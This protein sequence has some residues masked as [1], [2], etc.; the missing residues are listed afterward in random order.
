MA[1]TPN[2]PTTPSET[3]NTDG[4]HQA[5]T[6]SEIDDIN[7]LAYMEAVAGLS[8]TSQENEDD[9]DDDDDEEVDEEVEDEEEDEETERKYS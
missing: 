6:E 3:E 7:A 9:E 2:V 5:E 8:T 4:D 1:D